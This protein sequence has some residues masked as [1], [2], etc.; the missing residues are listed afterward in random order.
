MNATG[1][2]SSARCQNNRYGGEAPAKWHIVQRL[3][4][5]VR[6]LTFLEYHLTSA[7]PN[8]QFYCLIN[9]MEG[10]KTLL[11]FLPFLLRT[12]LR[13]PFG[14]RRWASSAWSPPWWLPCPTTPFPWAWWWVDWLTW[15]SLLRRF[16]RTLEEARRNTSGT[17]IFHS[18][19]FLIS[20]A[21]DKC[22]FNLIKLARKLGEMGKESLLSLSLSLSSR[23][24]WV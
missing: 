22:L 15:P 24:Q 14:R 18:F 3:S 7:L 11:T 6:C 13:G 2:T 9:W 23:G 12:V 5:S 16:P 20:A 4:I 1:S 8:M 10:E 21:D 17:W 19:T